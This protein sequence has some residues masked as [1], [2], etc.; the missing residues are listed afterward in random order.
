[1]PFAST[2][3]CI[4]VCIETSSVL[5]FIIC[6][7][8][9]F[10]KIWNYLL[11]GF[12]SK[13]CTLIL[14]CVVKLIT[15]L[16]VKLKFQTIPLF[17][18]ILNVN[19]TGLQSERWTITITAVVNFMYSMLQNTSLLMRRA[20]NFMTDG[21]QYRGAS[22]NMPPLKTKVILCCATWRPIS[23]I[24]TLAKISL[25]LKKIFVTEGF[26]LSK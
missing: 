6:D 22:V 24:Y 4:P 23:L 16:V 8:Q 9:K 19:H 17:I 12:Y 26:L 5:I 2:D 20:L 1:M 18:H 3:K 15:Q 13:A 25:V 21:E 7:C 11:S 10:Q 14:P